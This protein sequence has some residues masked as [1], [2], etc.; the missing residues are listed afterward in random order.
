[1][2]LNSPKVI[3]LVFL[4]AVWILNSSCLILPGPPAF[5]GG[6]RI[7]AFLGVAN[8]ESASLPPLGGVPNRGRV[9][10][11]FPG[12][13]GSAVSFMGVTDAFGISDY[14]NALTNAQWSIAI[15]PA[16]TPPC[17]ESVFVE[18]VPTAGAELLYFCHP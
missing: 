13:T 14:P 17:P 1:M 7:H 5:S 4:L 15:G 18:P 11:S 2:R 3:S 6:I 9:L 12:G 10:Q 16:L 8:S